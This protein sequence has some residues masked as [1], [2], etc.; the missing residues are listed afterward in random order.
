[1]PS[2]ILVKTGQLRHKKPFSK[3]FMQGQ[4]KLL[5]TTKELH[6]CTSSASLECKR[7]CLKEENNLC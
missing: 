2:N 1:M 3:V 6:Y 4:L 7:N 5:V